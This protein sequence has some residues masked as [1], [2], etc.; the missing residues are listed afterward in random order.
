MHGFANHFSGVRV[1]LIGG[2]CALVLAIFLPAI[3]F[4]NDLPSTA[5]ENL[6]FSHILPNQVEVLGHINT[7]AM[8]AQGFMWFGAATVSP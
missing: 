3:A 8:D 4:S 7:L 6:V 1:A 2:L 5:P